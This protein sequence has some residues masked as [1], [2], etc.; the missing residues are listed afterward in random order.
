M[1]LLLVCGECVHLGSAMTARRKSQCLNKDLAGFE[2][3]MPQDLYHNR[4]VKDLCCFKH[5]TVK[6]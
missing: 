5:T 2:C 1:Y 6:K 3:Q 4:N